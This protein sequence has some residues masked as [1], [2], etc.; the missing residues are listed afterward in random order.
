MRFL[1]FLFAL[2]TVMAA[3]L[4]KYRDMTPYM[5]IGYQKDN[6]WKA[7]TV[8]LELEW[9]ICPNTCLNF[10]MLLEQKFKDTKFHRIIRGFMMQ[11]GDFT[12]MNGTGGHSLLGTDKFPDENF[13]LKHTS[14]GV[15]SMANAGKDTNGSQFFITFSAT[16]WLDGKHVVFGRVSPASLPLLMEIQNVETSAGDVPVKDVTIMDCGFRAKSSDRRESSKVEEDSA[17]SGDE[18]LL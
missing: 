17:L 12:R 3:S 11:G 8:E 9:E 18:E 16:T 15:L 4:E 2:I 7:I 10:A 6:S 5:M 14:A 13:K 1:R